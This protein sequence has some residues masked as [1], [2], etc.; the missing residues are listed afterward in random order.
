MLYIG[1]S[2]NLHRQL[3]S[4][5]LWS[6]QETRRTQQEEFG[7]EASRGAHKT[8]AFQS[9]NMKTCGTVFRRVNLTAVVFKHSSDI[10][11]CAIWHLSAGLTFVH[12]CVCHLVCW[13]FCL[14]VL[15]PFVSFQVMC[16]C[17][18]FFPLQYDA[19]LFWARP[20]G[21]LAYRI[22]SSCQAVI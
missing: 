3:A 16:C 5:L 4:E 13:S 15:T 10:S 1:A 21:L 22:Y 2:G 20:D 19:C 8:R 6:G 18:F 14:Q 7:R 17:F 12:V 11:Y 9:L